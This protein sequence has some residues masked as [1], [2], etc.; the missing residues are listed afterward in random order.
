MV[1]FWVY[2]AQCIEF[3]KGFGTLSLPT[4]TFG[5]G[6]S[7]GNTSPAQMWYGKVLGVW[8][9]MYWC[10]QWFWHL[11]PPNLHFWNPW[12]IHLLHKCNMVRFWVY[13]VQCSEFSNG[14]GTLS[15]PTYT[16]GVGESLGNTS[17]AQMWYGKVLGVWCSMHWCFQWFWHLKPP[18]LH[19]WCGGILG[20]YI[21]CPNVIW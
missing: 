11:K 4:Y 10:F 12:A 7:L 3:S 18:N 1:R 17:P 15:L 21:S 19:F 2:D 16:F 8:C 14:F 5:V 20:Q 9:S 13:D 6:E